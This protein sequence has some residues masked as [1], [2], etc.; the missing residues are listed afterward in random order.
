[1]VISGILPVF[2]KQCYRAKNQ[3]QISSGQ[4]SVLAGKTGSD[5]GIKI[6]DNHFIHDEMVF[7]KGESW[8]EWIA[9]YTENNTGSTV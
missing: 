2:R 4:I 7:L 9:F 6:Q 8:Y 3:K 5:P 1:V